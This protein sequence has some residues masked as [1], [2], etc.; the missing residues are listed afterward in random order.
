MMRWSSFS[1]KFRDLG[2]RGFGVLGFRD[3][4]SKVY[5]ALGFM[6]MVYPLGMCNECSGSSE[7]HMGFGI[8]TN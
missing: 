3:L 2:F 1:G 7:I 6:V 4:G 5:K 8:S